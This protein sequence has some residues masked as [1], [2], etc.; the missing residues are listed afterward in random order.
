MGSVQVCPRRRQPIPARA[1]QLPNAPFR[2]WDGRGRES[3]D[4]LRV[5]CSQITV[6]MFVRTSSRLLTCLYIPTHSLP[7]TL[8]KLMCWHICESIQIVPAVVRSIQRTCPL[9]I[10]TFSVEVA[11]SSG[12]ISLMQTE[13][14]THVLSL[15]LSRTHT[16]THSG[17]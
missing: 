4:E 10:H 9:G 17:P 15:P 7:S 13:Q 11:T 12:S 6:R 1:D 5:S 8:S 16:Y 14:V 3:R 2:C